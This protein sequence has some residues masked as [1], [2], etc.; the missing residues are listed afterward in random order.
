VAVRR[1]HLDGDGSVPRRNAEPICR[2]TTRQLAARYTTTRFTER[3]LQDAEFGPHF[4]HTAAIDD[5][6]HALV[7]AKRRWPYS[8]GKQRCAVLER[9][10]VLDPLIGTRVVSFEVISVTQLSCRRLLISLAGESP[11]GFEY[12]AGQELLLVVAND[13]TRTDYGRYLVK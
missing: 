12:S 5:S 9:G 13:G 4:R 8:A 7:T 2:S 11:W 6:C 3:D 10:A 1:P